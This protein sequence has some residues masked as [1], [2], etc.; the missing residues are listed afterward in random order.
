MF[1]PLKSLVPGRQ[2]L[3][4]TLITINLALFSYILIDFLLYHTDYPVKER[5][6]LLVAYSSPSV[7]PS[8]GSRQ[9]TDRINENSEC[10]HRDAYYEIEENHGENP[11]NQMKWMGEP[12]RC[13][14]KGHLIEKLD[15]INNFRRGFSLRFVDGVEDRTHVLPWL[16]ASKESFHQRKRRVYLDFGANRFSTSV[17]WFLR[18]YPCDF[19]EVHAFEINSKLL[20]KPEKGFPEKENWADA[21][22][23][24]TRVKRMPGV[25][26][27]MLDRITTYNKYVS[28][29]DNEGNQAINITRFIKEDLKLSAQDFVLVKMDIEGSEWPILNNWM[30]DPE[31]PHII[32]ELFVEIHYSHPSMTAYNWDAFKPKSRDEAKRLL[33]DLRWKG[34]YA[35]FWP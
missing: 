25:P 12:A 2:V 7:N 5:P 9:T 13:K 32:D 6:S 30:D 19:T 14:V 10:L 28:D 24:S 20:K 34:F 27:W 11:W 26:Q 8:L 17:G 29:A 15:D 18:M 35:H 4:R 22:A 16:L 3:S 33:A 31:M 1:D 21:T 23:N